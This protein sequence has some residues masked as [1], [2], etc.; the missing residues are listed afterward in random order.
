M[1]VRIRLRL[2]ATKGSSPGEVLEAS[3]LV[4]SGYEASRDECSLPA[5]AAEALG[6]WPSLTDDAEEFTVRGFTGE[7]TVRAVP[8]ALR[9]Q[10]FDRLPDVLGASS[11]PSVHG[12]M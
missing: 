11:L 6:L 10:H 7:A 5:A 3:A 8:D 2:E 9:A 12:H 4:N 1:A